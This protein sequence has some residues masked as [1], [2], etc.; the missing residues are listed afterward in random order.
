MCHVTHEDALGAGATIDEWLEHHLADGWRQRAIHQG[1][2]PLSKA[3]GKSRWST[4]A[5]L[6][7]GL[8]EA[9]AT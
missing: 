4:D 9:P 2:L 8:L 7:L 1:W 5:L 3:F 6:A